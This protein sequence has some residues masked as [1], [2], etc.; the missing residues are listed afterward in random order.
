MLIM[1]KI[2]MKEEELNRWESIST[3]WLN[4]SMRC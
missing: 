4:T 1:S 3:R 2:E